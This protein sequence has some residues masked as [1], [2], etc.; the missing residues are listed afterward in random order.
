VPRS[1]VVRLLSGV[2][3]SQNLEL[4]L[5]TVAGLYR[6]RAHEAPPAPA[7]PIATGRASDATQLYVIHL[8]HARAADVAATVNALYGRASALG[9]PASSPGT[10]SSNLAQNAFQPALT[11]TPLA[12]QP[13]LSA[14]KSAALSGETAII[15]DQG[16]NSLLIRANASDFELISAAVKELDVRPLQVLIEVLIVE[17]QKNSNWAAGLGISFPNQ[18][19]KGTSTSIGGS[20]PS[21]GLGDFAFNIMRGGSPAFTASLTAAAAKGEARILSRPIVLAE[22]NE[23][24]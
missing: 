23:E 15:P 24:A 4:A 9:E 19:V 6:V 11:P 22:N 3:S 8:S 17:V 13:V 16:T 12:Q 21:A 2:V 1:D 10:L 18:Q 5:D 14:G 7:Q 20:T